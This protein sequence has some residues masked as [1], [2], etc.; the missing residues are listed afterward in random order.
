MKRVLGQAL[1]VVTVALLATAFTPA[2]AENDQSIFIRAALA[3]S[4]NRQGGRCVYTSDPTQTGLFEG[5]VDVAIAE[6]YSAVLLIGNQLAARGD[7]ANTRAESNRA[8]INGAVVR[9]TDPNGGL[10]GEFTSLATGFVEPQL[11]NQASYGPISVTAID[12][13]TMNKIAGD[14]ELGGSKLV[15]ANIKAFGRT[16]GGV[17][18]ESGEFQLPIRICNGCLVTFEGFDD[19]A[20]PDILECKRAEDAA[21][22]T[23]ELPCSPGQDETTPCLFC[24]RALCGL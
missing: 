7:S 24:R 5:T 11:N 15:A 4:T 12:V 20:T 21:G 14:M 3:P 2:C 8:H 23:D 22:G 1:S 13:P 16:V 9:V 18:L 10:I 17:D 19:K 6:S